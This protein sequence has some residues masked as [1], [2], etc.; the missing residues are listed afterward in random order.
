L[1]IVRFEPQFSF[2]ATQ[3]AEYMGAQF[4]NPYICVKFALTPDI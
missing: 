4:A 3:I 2:C 1:S